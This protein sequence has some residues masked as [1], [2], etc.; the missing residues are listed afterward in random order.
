MMDKL[1]NSIFSN[2]YPDPDRT[3][4]QYN[5]VQQVLAELQYYAWDA[6]GVEEGGSHL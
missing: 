4:A 2:S 1:I 6:E 3:I 5:L